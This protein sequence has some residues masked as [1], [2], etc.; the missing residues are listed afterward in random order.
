MLATLTSWGGAVTDLSADAW[1]A[2]GTIAATLVALFLPFYSTRRE[3]RRQDALRASDHKAAQQAL[4]DLHRDVCHTAERVVAYRNAARDIFSTDT[5]YQTTLAAMRRIGVNCEILR[6]VLAEM[7]KRP[8]LTDGALYCAS[9]AEQIAR[10][11]AE[12]AREWVK[13]FGTPHRR[14]EHSSNY[15][16]IVLAGLDDLCISTLARIEDVKRSFCFGP[17]AGAEKISKK[18]TDLVTALNRA[19]DEETAPPPFDATG[20]E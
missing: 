6:N 7:K 17:S 14:V 12:G 15:M 11:V 19:S 18:Y 3:W 2:I 9:A 4:S 10:I 5:S 8:Q 13:S 20:H 1:S 16:H